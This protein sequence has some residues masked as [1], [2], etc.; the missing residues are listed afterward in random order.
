M[1]CYRG[2]WAIL[3]EVYKAR[4]QREVMTGGLAHKSSEGN[5]HCQELN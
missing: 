4:R 1:L 5:E 2:K 3:M